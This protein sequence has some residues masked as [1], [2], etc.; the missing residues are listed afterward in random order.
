MTHPPWFRFYIEV[1]HD[2][3]ILKL[4]DKLFR[5]WVKLLCVAGKN[6]GLL[7]PSEDLA[8][9]LRET[10]ETVSCD[11]LSLKNLG[12]IDTTRAG[13]MIHGWSKRQYKSDSS[14]ERVKR[15]RERFKAVTVTAPDTDTD[16]DTDTERKEGALT[17]INGRPSTNGST[18]LYVTNHAGSITL[19]QQNKEEPDNS[20]C[21]F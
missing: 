5:I 8:I 17:R 21:P 18:N 13:M 1:L 19:E 14:T 15:Y 11:I 4:D 6:G 9:E 7:P 20:G 3:K 2:P 12:F 10:E 16:T